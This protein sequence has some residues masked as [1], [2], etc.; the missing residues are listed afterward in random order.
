MRLSSNQAL[1]LFSLLISS[2]QHD[3]ERFLCM[4]LESRVKLS[5]EIIDQQ[6]GCQDLEDDFI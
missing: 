2:L 6:E 5:N 1:Q 4:D 3:E